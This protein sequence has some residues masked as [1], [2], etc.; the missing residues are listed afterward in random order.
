MATTRPPSASTSASRWWCCPVFWD[1]YDNA[2]RVDELGF[3]TRLATYA[4]AA[5]ELTRRDR[6][7]ARRRQLCRRLG[8]RVGPRPD[9]PG[10][11]KA[12]D[13]IER[14]ADRE[15]GR[16]PGC[17]AAGSARLTR[18][19][20]AGQRWFAARRATSTADRAVCADA[21]AGRRDA[22]RSSRSSTRPA[23]AERY[24]MPGGE[25]LWGP[26]L[27]R[28]AAGPGATASDWPTGPRRRTRDGPSGSSSATS[29]TRRTS[30]DDRVSS[31]A[32][33]VSGRASHPEVEL[34]T[35]L[36]DR[37][38]ASRR[39]SAQCT[40]STAR[41]EWAVALRPGAR[42]GGR[43][44]LGVV[45]APRRGCR[46]RCRD[47]Q[48]LGRRGRRAHRR[49]PR[50]A[51]RARDATCVAER[52]RAR[53]RSAPSGRST[54]SRRLVRAR[55]AGAAARTVSPAA[56]ASARPHASRRS[57]ASTA[58]TTSASCCA[59][60]AG[61]RVI[62]FEGEPTRP[63]EERRALDSPLRDVASMLR[64]IDH[65]PLWVLRDR[66]G[67][68]RGR[69]RRVERC[70]PGRVPR[71]VRREP[72]RPGS[73]CSCGRSRLEKAAYEF[74]Y[75]EAFLP[76]W[77]PV[78]AAGAELLLSPR[79]RRVSH[80]SDALPRR[81]PGEPETLAALLDAYG[82]R[83]GPLDGSRRASTSAACSSPAWAAPASPRSP[84]CSRLASRRR[85]RGG[86]VGVGR[87][88]GTPPARR[89]AR[90]RDLRLRRRRRRPSRRPNATAG[91]AAS[92]PSRTHPAAPLGAAADV[93]LPLLAGRGARRHRVQDLPG[94]RGRAALLRRLGAPA[95]TARCGPPSRP[96]GHLDSRGTSGCAR[97]RR[98]RRRPGRRRRRRPSVSPRPSSRR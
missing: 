75:A 46:G 76:E 61:Y 11:V 58:T 49:A 53:R 39:R 31:S 20:L 16:V 23:A 91:R 18:E 81:R 26:L 9:G 94:D 43:G 85:R 79:G 14:L 3:G 7:P 84:P 82:G 35:F 25:P 30:L 78:A 33:G 77:L 44:R 98:A 48:P 80:P 4:C 64:S 90:R 38:A 21:R 24:A 87:A 45:P 17:V 28:L 12:A 93:V 56:A 42:P 89:P 8:A 95:S 66:A 96:S 54:R 63:L 50:R 29:R 68:P 86:R 10:T 22:A 52:A 32:T 15:P 41:E 62:D 6:R 88:V 19:R 37:F 1:Q 55:T 65:V 92:S 67:A 70:V 59:R 34:V 5:E 72:A 40:T 97:P 83:D 13:L 73:R 57:A 74:G 36:G 2:Q 60:R 71:G 51:R 27:R 69:S 47:R